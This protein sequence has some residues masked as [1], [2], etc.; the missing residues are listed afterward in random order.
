MDWDDLRYF[1]KV[2][3]TGGLSPAGRFLRVDASTVGRHIEVLEEALGHR[4]FVRTQRGYGLTEAGERLLRWSRRVEG[5]F[6]ELQGAFA[7]RAEEPAGVVSVATTE[8]IAAGFLVPSL[9]AFHARYP[10]VEVEIA[11]G[12]HSVNLSRREADVALRVVRPRQGNVLARRIGEVGLALYASRAYVEA[13]GEPRRANGFAGHDLI[14]WPA[15]YDA[16]PQIP[17]LRRIAARAGV[18]V[19][20]TSHIVRL[21]AA[22]AGL[23]IVLLACIAADEEP[24]LLRL[25]VG[26]APPMQPLWTGVHADLAHRA[27]IRAVLDHL[28]AAAREQAARL[29][30]ET[31]PG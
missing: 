12:P 9:R 16:I 8:P 14:E 13:R 25:T 1:L 21:T 28:A 6:A 7:A 3:E 29:R 11:A 30:G 23:G 24:A 15:D 27:S 22:R 26:E 10:A 31:A 19:R 4:L 5:E 2:A 20:S 18:P 17:W